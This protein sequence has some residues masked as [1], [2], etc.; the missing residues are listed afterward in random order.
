MV[1]LCSTI[2]LLS[3]L[4]ST[5]A[6]QHVVVPR[7]AAMSG[8]HRSRL[9][10]LRA[11]SDTPPPPSEEEDAEEDPRAAEFDLGGSISDGYLGKSSVEK[12]LIRQLRERSRALEKRKE[13][14]GGGK[15]AVGG[16]NRGSWNRGG[17]PK[18]RTPN[19]IFGSGGGASPRKDPTKEGTGAI[20]GQN[21]G[22]WGKGGSPMPKKEKKPEDTPKL[23]S[24]SENS[25][26]LYATGQVMYHRRYHYR[27]VISGWD[28]VCRASPA[29]IQQMGVDRLPAGPKQPFYNVLVAD[30]STRYAA[31]GSLR[32]ADVPAPIPHPDV[33]WYFTAFRGTRYI[34]TVKLHTAYPE[35][36][37]KLASEASGEGDVAMGSTEEEEEDACSDE[38]WDTG[39]PP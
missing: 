32:P 10:P 11:S 23:R 20:G 18:P 1:R 13:M 8:G 19:D 26:V 28:P 22:S 15:G 30:G 17:S 6:F 5:E 14:K 33:G 9:C 25:E 37:A 36:A 2:L 29:W 7:E 38:H 16:Q 3:A 34:P 27:C 39:L 35:D 31:Q 21:R 24:D 12:D 4:L